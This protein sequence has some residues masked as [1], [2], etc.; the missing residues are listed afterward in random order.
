MKKDLVFS[1][2]VY[3]LIAV[4]GLWGTVIG[5]RLFFLQVIQSAFFRARADG[6]QK[7]TIPIVPPRGAIFDRKGNALAV[8]VQVKSVY[9]VH[10]EVKDVDATAKT[11]SAIIGIPAG[12]IADKLEPKKKFV[13]IKRKISDAEVQAINKAGLPGI[14]LYDEFQR[15]YPN[16]DLAAQVLGYVGIDEQGLGGLEAQ[17]EDILKGVDGKVVYLQ[18]GRRRSYN[19]SKEPAQPGANLITTL[20]KNIQYFVR[21][22]VREA[23]AK[24]H[25]SG[26]H[27]VVMDPRN[28]QILA[29][30]NYP[31]FDP[32]NY[33]AYDPAYLKN[34]NIDHTYEPGST[35]KILTVGAALEEGLTAP[36]ERIDC[37]QGSIVVAGQ[38]IRDHKS[39]GVLTVSEIL[40]KSSDVGAITL[41]LRLKEERMAK[42]IK[43]WGFGNRTGIDLPGE[44]RGLTKSASK[45]PKGSIG[46]IA[47]GQ[48]IGVT[49]LQIVS[50]VS[51]VANGGSLPR[52]YV[53][54]EVRDA[55]GTVISSTEPM[56]QRVMSLTS[57]RQMQDMLEKVVT[58][59]TATAAKLDGY[60]AA[61]KTGTAQ[62]SDGAGYSETKL[63]ASF[64]GYAPAS[65]PV[66][67][68]VVVVDAPVGAH[69]GG[70]VA[71]PIFKRIADQILHYKG[72][73]PDIQDYAPPRYTAPPSKRQSDPGPMARPSAPEELQII[74]ANF[75]GL[76]A[77]PYQPGDITV[78]DFRG[79]SE[80]EAFDESRRLGLRTK[81]DGLGGRIRRQYPLPGAQVRSGTVVEVGLSTK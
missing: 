30:D 75:T 43:L 14:G 18:D 37:L 58:E 32:N 6:Q 3:I 72:I 68:M 78:P 29:M 40:E 46:Y 26:I 71:A 81:S 19:E 5:A 21:Q 39:F 59:G 52:P 54:S 61:G 34:G 49:P 53:V 73:P 74:N 76:A 10:A 77:K 63:I 69:H 2:R 23:V 80:G 7:Q 4:M 12:D 41:G 51:M 1:R 57:D 55:Q 33:R 11:L 62:K 56:S 9:G 42:Y 50:L 66:I 70:E 15:N 67:A 60:R 65:N 17:Y 27:V 64:A 25:A 44:E 45:W 13:W 24:T 8:S 47:M 31:T 28:G 79:K 36:D 38:R 16:N 20:D 22:A 35:F 48:G